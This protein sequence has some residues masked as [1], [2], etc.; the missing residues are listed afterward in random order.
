MVVITNKMYY[1][2]IL[3]K[4]NTKREGGILLMFT[5]L[6]GF[7]CLKN[8][9]VIL[10]L[11]EK[12]S[13]DAEILPFY[14]YDIFDNQNNPVGKISIRIGHNF[15]SYYNGN[16]GFEIFDKHRGFNYSLYASKLVLKVAQA[17]K[18][19]DLYITCKESN[20]AS[21]KIIEKLGAEKKEIVNI[22]KECFFYKENLE[23]YIIYLLN[24]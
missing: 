9:K 23:R 1:K 3:Q 5:F 12:N 19:N 15:N 8:D 14:Y 24:L 22:P 21:R 17:H 18:M 7:E 6:E 2:D 13:G 11:I 10:K 16:I 4:C 20:I